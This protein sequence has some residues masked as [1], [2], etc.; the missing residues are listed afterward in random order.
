LILRTP[1]YM[2]NKK[3][4]FNLKLEIINISIK[5]AYET[6]DNINQ[7]ELQAAIQIAIFDDIFRN[8]TADIPPFSASK[9]WLENFLNR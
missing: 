6:F 3:H 9:G 1:I 7:Y 4:I 5:I 2:L 8:T